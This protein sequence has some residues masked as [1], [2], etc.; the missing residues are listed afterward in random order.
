M[1]QDELIVK[2]GRLRT[3]MRGEEAV[4]A[5]RFKEQVEAYLIEVETAFND[6][7]W[8]TA[9]AE[10]ENA[11]KISSIIEYKLSNKSTQSLYFCQG[12]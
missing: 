9:N 1:L 12:K 4:Q 10:T 7:A 6:K 8:Q 3:Q 2:V 5:Q 11:Q